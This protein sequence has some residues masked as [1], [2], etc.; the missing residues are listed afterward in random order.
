M[1]RR[2][3]SKPVAVKPTGRI[4]AGVD[5]DREYRIYGEIAPATSACSR[6]RRS[7]YFYR[8]NAIAWMR[9]ALRAG[10]GNITVAECRA[11]ALRYL[12]HY[13]AAKAAAGGAL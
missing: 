8:K 6:Y 4:V 9:S 2:T 13:K 12:A 5:I 1:N 7:P 11:T 10:L 3:K